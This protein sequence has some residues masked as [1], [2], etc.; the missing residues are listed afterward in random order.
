MSAHPAVS[1]PQRRTHVPEPK[2]GQTQH[3]DPGQVW[4]LAQTE[5]GPWCMRPGQ[6]TAAQSL[7][8]GS[9]STATEPADGR[10]SA[11]SLNLLP[12]QDSVTVGDLFIQRMSS[13]PSS[14][15]FQLLPSLHPCPRWELRRPP[16]PR[17]ELR[18]PPCPRREL[19]HPPCPVP[20]NKEGGCARGKKDCT[21]MLCLC[22][23]IS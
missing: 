23:T 5:G 17:Q 12:Y 11:K 7:Q 18:R 20:E 14:F 16:C 4:L 19:R 13:V 10:I 21:T 9:F 2:V 22:S 1:L 3:P 8:S 15:P 6:W